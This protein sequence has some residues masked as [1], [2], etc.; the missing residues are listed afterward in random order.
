MSLCN[1]I[2]RKIRAL[3]IS[4]HFKNIEDLALAAKVPHL[5]KIETGNWN[6]TLGTLLKLSSTLGVSLSEFFI[7]EE[8][9]RAVLFR[10]VRHRLGPELSQKLLDTYDPLLV[11]QFFNS[12]VFRDSTVND[13]ELEGRE[14]IDEPT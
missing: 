3:R 11:L 14:S 6:P 10:F 5:G 1:K 8:R 12:E 7:E 9:D 13:I 4:H 2:G